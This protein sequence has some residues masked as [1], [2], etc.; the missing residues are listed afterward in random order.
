[1]CYIPWWILTWFWDSQLDCYCGLTHQV[2]K[3]LV[4]CELFAH[5]YLSGTRRRDKIKKNRVDKEKYN[6]NNNNMCL[7]NKWCTKQLLTTHWLVP[8]PEQQSEPV[9]ALSLPSSLCPLASTSS[10]TEHL[11]LFWAT[12]QQELKGWFVTNTVFLPN[13]QHNIIPNTRRGKKK[14]VSVETR[15]ISLYLFR[16]VIITCTLCQSSMDLPNN[17]LL[18]LHPDQKSS[19]WF[20]I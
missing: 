1:M 4:G 14:S 18:F 13:L 19:L 3:H 12:A 8:V 11:W 6:S 16:E 2:A 9:P 7:Q 20:R 15:A 10:R 5:I 17:R